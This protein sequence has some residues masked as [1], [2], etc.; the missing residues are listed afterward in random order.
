MEI[1][2]RH[3]LDEPLDPA[4]GATGHRLHRPRDLAILRHFSGPRDP[5]FFLPPVLPGGFGVAND[6]LDR[7]D[8][9]GR[10]PGN[11]GARTGVG[12]ATARI[13]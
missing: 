1:P 5:A 4:L 6:G 10:N 13:Q 3:E 2:T 7:T 12:N 9:D 11:P 8:E